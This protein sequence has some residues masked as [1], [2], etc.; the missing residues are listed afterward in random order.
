MTN[1]IQGNSHQTIL[2]ISQQKLY[3]PEGNGTI[4]L[5]WCKGRSLKEISPGCSL[6]GLMLKL[7]F[8]YFGHCMRRADSFDAGKDWRQEKKGARE[9]EMVGWRH[10]LNGHEFQQATEDGE[11][12]GSLA[13]CSPWGRKESDTTYQLNN[14]NKKIYLILIKIKTYF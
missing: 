5:K 10:W 12:Q 9:D 4:Y 14:R 13:C 7:K 6:E 1:N 3:K 11:G 8:Q 2:A